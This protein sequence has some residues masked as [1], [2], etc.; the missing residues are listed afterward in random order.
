MTTTNIISFKAQSMIEAKLV[1]K[2]KY[3]TSPWA[4]DGKINVKR[5]QTIGL[6]VL[7]TV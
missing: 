4:K 7:E 6:Q 5:K 2:I 3:I 1:K